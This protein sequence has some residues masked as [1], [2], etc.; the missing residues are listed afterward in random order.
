MIKIEEFAEFKKSYP[1][2]KVVGYSELVGNPTVEVDLT[3]NLYQLSLKEEA[4][5]NVD[6]LVPCYL[7]DVEAKKICL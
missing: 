6:A 5:E 7:K 2:Y 3:E 4:V 1:D